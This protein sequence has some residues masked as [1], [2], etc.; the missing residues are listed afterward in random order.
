M[1]EGKNTNGTYH[2]NSDLEHY[3]VARSNFFTFIVEGLDGL[4]KSDFNL[5]TPSKKDIITG[6]QEIIKLS[7]TK[8]S[9]PHFSIDPISIRRGNSVVKFAGNPTFDSGSIEVQDFVG[10]DVKSVLMAW[11]ALAYDVVNDKGGRA[12]DYKKNCSLIEYTQDYEEIRRWDLVGC[13]V[14][15]LKEDDF[16]M[17][18]DGDRKISITIQYDRAVMHKA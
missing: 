5:V 6:G 15:D 17:S 13:W 14:S 3:E 10:L 9:V 8:A 7:V 2:I 16:D 1:I 18:A 11:Q 4:V 12:K